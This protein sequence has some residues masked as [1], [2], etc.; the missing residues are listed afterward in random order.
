L[1]AL[2]AASIDSELE[3]LRSDRA[4]GN[5]HLEGRRGPEAVEE[6][7]LELER[8]RGI[9]NGRPGKGTATR[10][11]EQRGDDKQSQDDPAEALDAPFLLL[12]R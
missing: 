12:K 9:A 3:L 2:Q 4:P 7:V 10:Q 6:R 11:T 1:D 5:P 8:R